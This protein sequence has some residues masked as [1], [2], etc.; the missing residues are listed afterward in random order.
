MFRRDRFRSTA[1]QSTLSDLTKMTYK[2]VYAFYKLAGKGENA[3]PDWQVVRRI[4]EI[5][6]GLDGLG[7]CQQQHA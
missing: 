5:H 1:P 2:E 3:L 4:D 6:T 7:V